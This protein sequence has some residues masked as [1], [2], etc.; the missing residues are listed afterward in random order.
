MNLLSGYAQKHA[1]QVW[2]WCLMGNHVH[3]LVVPESESSL[4]R[5]IGL[6]NLVYTQYLNRKVR[7]KKVGSPRKAADITEKP[8]GP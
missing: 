5:G 1:L 8:G 2:A 4:A 3:L 6:T 7:A